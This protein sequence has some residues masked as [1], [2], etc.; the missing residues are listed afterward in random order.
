[1]TGGSAGIGKGIAAAFADRRQRPHDHVPQGRQV[2]AAVAEELGADVDWLAGHTSAGPRTAEAVH[3]R[4]HR[5]LR[6]LRH[7]RQ[8]RRHQPLGRAGS[9]T[10][11]SPCW[12]R[13]T[14]STCAARCAWT[15]LA[16][17]TWM[18]EHGG[19]VINIASV[20][21]LQDVEPDLGVYGMFKAGARAH[22][23]AA[24]RRDGPPGPGQLHRPRPH[25]HRLRPHPVGGSSGGPRWPSRMPLKRLG[26]PS[27][28][29]E[30]PVG[31]R[32]ASG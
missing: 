2:E 4:Q 17:Q 21:G 6:G 11:T 3:R 22:D 19:A 5:A 26:E 9:S 10:S 31:R 20:G 15:Q 1:M 14:R 32:R 8:Q 30:A 23:Q 12:T 13:P 24:R 25:P 18:R 28:I 7:P 16:W 27:D 29:G